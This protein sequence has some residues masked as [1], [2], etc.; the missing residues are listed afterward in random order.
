MTTD[1]ILDN[2]NLDNLFI[3]ATESAD[4]KFEKHGKVPATFTCVGD[5]EIKSVGAWNLG[6]DEQRERFDKCC[7]L[8][9]VAEGARA[10][11]Y[12]AEIWT[13]LA[14]SLDGLRPSQH[15]RRQECVAIRAE[16]PGLRA[17]CFYSI[18]RDKAGK[19]KLGS[20]IGPALVEPIDRGDQT[21]PI[22]IPSPAER[23]QAA[24]EL[25]QLLVISGN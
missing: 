7:R 15:P 23:M 8:L 10:T 12:I 19:P 16:L 5:H 24:M 17:N 1:N 18:L 13:V 3:F 22:E 25:Q 2:P 21:L 20:P 11:V 14:A 9:C 4:K 6:T